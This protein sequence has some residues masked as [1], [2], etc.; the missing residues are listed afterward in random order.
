[1]AEDVM[2]KEAI[3]AIDQ[4]QRKRARDLLTRLLRADQ[5][6][7]DYWLWM[8]SV[9]ETPKEQ[10]LCLQKALQIDPN[11]QAARQGMVLLG[12]MPAPALVSPTPLVRR[13]WAIPKEKAPPATG[14]Q[15][16]MANPIARWISIGGIGGVVVL[17][18]MLGFMG[19]GPGRGLFGGVRLTITPLPWTD[20]P[21]ATLLPTNTPRVR[22]PT[23]T[24]VGP[25]PLWMLLEATYTPTPLYVNT[26]HPINESYRAGLRAMQNNDL[27][28]MLGFMQQAATVEPN[29]PDTHYYVGEAHRLM[30]DYQA[31][32]EA[33]EAALN[34][35]VSFAPAYLGLARAR[36]GLD[37]QAEVLDDLDQAIRYDPSLA[38]AYIERA[39]YSIQQDEYES[40]LDDLAFLDEL[41]PES[42]LLFLLRAQAY[43][44]LE[45]NEAA[46]QAA[47][48]ANDLDI[49]LLPAYYVLGQAALTNGE[50]RLAV[51]AL[52]TY[53]LHRP[54]N[55]E[56]WV[57][58]ARAYSSSNRDP[59]EIAAAA[60][61][62][63]E[64]NDQ[65][66]EAY[67]LRGAAYLALE[68][69]Q[70][71]VN[72]FFQARRLDSESFDANLGFGRALLLADRPSDG[73]SQ[74]NSANALVE[75][76]VQQAQ[77]YYWRAMALEALDENRAALVDWQALEE[78]LTEMLPDMAK[79]ALPEAWIEIAQGRLATLTPPPVTP[80]ATATPSPSITA[81]ITP[82]RTPTRTSTRTP[83]GTPTRTTT[84][85]PPSRTPTP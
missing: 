13:E 80:T 17:M 78:L 85:P 44:G 2:L 26:P 69:G 60:S 22:T 70:D 68:E 21:T 82:T 3:D 67:M 79:G 20:R 15:A 31:A 77:I 38:G 40:A 64:L 49:T 66:F 32:I 50:N 73:R 19:F 48:S 28:G 27:P 46:L 59:E 11:N 42:P 75:N 4:G 12:A 45:Q 57:A 16:L 56:G 35:D 55:A 24:F 30:G 74:I 84:V 41:Q 25:T 29:I 5:E 8:S 63:L 34:M 18:L 76:D 6:N 39:A 65:L 7:S 23:P 33:Y 58:L 37:P 83:T 72:D 1:M 47:Q 10:I 36:L 61:Q 81:S 62:A 54:E 51:D 9:V 43:L 71:A 52:E 53:T 14:F